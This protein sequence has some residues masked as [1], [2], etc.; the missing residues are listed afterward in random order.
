ML[1][2]SISPTAH[3]ISRGIT[4][5][6]HG[7][8]LARVP[9]RIKANGGLGKQRGADY[10][11]IRTRAHGIESQGAHH[12]PRRHLAYIVVTAN[13]VDLGMVSALQNAT[14]PLLR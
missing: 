11:N 9:P 3:R 10:I 4:S 14:C 7:E 5:C 8:G 13:A 6:N 12:V 2:H 1:C